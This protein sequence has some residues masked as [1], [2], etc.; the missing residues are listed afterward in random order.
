MSE[1]LGIPAYG[2]CSLDGIAACR[3]EADLV[4]MTDAR[5]KEVYWA[6]YNS[7]GERIDG[8]HVSKP[9]DVP[10][11]GTTRLAGAG[12]RLYFADRNLLDRDYPMPS[13]LAER[14]RDRILTRAAS[15]PLT[16]LYLRRPDAV[17]P[18]VAK[19]V[20]Q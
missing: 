2:V 8:P 11:N 15:D 17:E 10:L 3:D 16:P 12:A 5:R 9:Q 14:A 6:R 13:A 1:T 18:G 20:T 19:P 4:V 7:D